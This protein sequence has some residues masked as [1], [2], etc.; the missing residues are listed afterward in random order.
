[1]DG[2]ER[3]RRMLQPQVAALHQ[4][5]RLIDHPQWVLASGDG[6]ALLLLKYHP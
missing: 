4:V 1:M 3:A 6:L 5:F 2:A